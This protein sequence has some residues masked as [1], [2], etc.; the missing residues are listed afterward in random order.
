MLRLYR[1]PPSA[2]QMVG[3]SGTAA[4]RARPT[5]PARLR[6]IRDASLRAGGVSTRNPEHWPALVCGDLQ[7]F[8]V[9]KDDA[10]RRN[11]RVEAGTTLWSTA[12]LSALSP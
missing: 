1:Y 5:A 10:D 11:E 7:S 9:W 8:Y 3:R 6:R 2:C 12:P 4:L